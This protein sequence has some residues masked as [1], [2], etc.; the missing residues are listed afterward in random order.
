MF[1]N[2]TIFTLDSE[3]IALATRHNTK[4]NKLVFSVMLKF[5]QLEGRYPTSNDIIDQTMINNVAMQLN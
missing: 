4:E 3:E 1:N 2:D 5:F